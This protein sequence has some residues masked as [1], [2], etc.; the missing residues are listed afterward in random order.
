MQGPIIEQP[1]TYFKAPLSTPQP[2]SAGKTG[3]WRTYRPVVDHGKCTGCQ[4][5]WLYCPEDTIII[6][7]NGKVDIEYEYCKGCGICASVC[8]FKAIEMVPESVEVVS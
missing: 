7:D 5:C 6:L 3:S 8:P 1:M 2:G 4:I